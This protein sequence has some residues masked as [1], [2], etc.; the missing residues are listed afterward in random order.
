MPNEPTDCAEP[1][2]TEWAAAWAKLCEMDGDDWDVESDRLDAKWKA[3]YVSEFVSFALS[4]QGWTEEN[5]AVWADEIVT[6]ALINHRGSPI[7]AARID[8][9]WCELEASDY[10]E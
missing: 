7:R 8:V 10:V 3:E 6:E 1:S 4:R 2:V 5:A 9:P